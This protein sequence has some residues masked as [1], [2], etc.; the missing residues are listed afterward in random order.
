MRYIKNINE[1]FDSQDMKDKMEI[2]YIMGNLHSDILNKWDKI[3][4]NKDNLSSL[5]GTIKL[6]YPVI[7][8]FHTKNSKIFNDPIKTF[9]AT[10]L[11]PIEG[12]EYLAQISLSYHNSL[13]YVSVILRDLQELNPDNFM[14][15]DFILNNTNDV[16]VIVKAFIVSCE[17]LGVIRKEHRNNILN[18]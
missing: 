11:E 5:I 18:N 2:P 15:R 17:G 9:Y 16:M 6:Q 7:N 13:Y 8:K 1:L 3:E 14:N 10:S 4:I 12:A